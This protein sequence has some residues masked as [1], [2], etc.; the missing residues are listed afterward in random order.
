MAKYVVLGATGQTGTATANALIG[1]ATVRVAVRNESKG[2]AWRAQ[3]AEVAI[4]EDIADVDALARAFEGVTGAYVLNPPDYASDNL[5][6]RAEQVISAV[7]EAAQRAH[8][9]KIVALSSIGGHLPQGT[10]HILTVYKME[11][12]LKSLPTKVAIGFVR[13][14]GFMENWRPLLPIA[15]QTGRLPSLYAPLDRAMPMVSAIDVGQTCA[16][17]LMQEWQNT[18]V[19]ELHG[20]HP[21]SPNDVAASF[22]KALERDVQAVTLPESE[23]SS[24]LAPMGFNSATIHSYSEMIR[25]FNDGTLVFEENGTKRIQRKTTIDEIVSSWLGGSSLS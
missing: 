2:A 20:P 9:S 19:W 5:L 3:G 7:A 22:S 14:A 12:K 16:D 8:L 13:A 10:G 18:Q 21:Y 17:M 6:T 15:Q 24:L 23:W 4:V 11:E 25:A 1:H